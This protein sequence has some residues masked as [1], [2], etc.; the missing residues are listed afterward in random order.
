MFCFCESHEEWLNSARSKFTDAS[1]SRLIEDWGPL[2]SEALQRHL[3]I[4]FQTQDIIGKIFACSE[5]LMFC[6]CESNEKRLNSVRSKFAD[7]SISQWTLCIIGSHVFE[8]C[9]PFWLCYQ[10]WLLR[11]P[12]AAF[13]FN[14]TR[15][16]TLWARFLFLDGWKRVPRTWQSMREPSCSWLLGE[17][18]FFLSSPLASQAYLPLRAC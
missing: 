5:R 2:A 15:V 10:P 16:Q 6:F 13:M 9:L 8:P 12:S 1:I 4:D 18:L 7:A 11:T 3:S 14:Q 17:P